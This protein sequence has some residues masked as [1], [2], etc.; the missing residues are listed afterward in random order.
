MILLVRHGRT[1]MNAA[2]RLQGRVDAP[3][4]EL[5]RAQARA[6]GAVLP[7]ADRIVCSPLAR[8]RQTAEIIAGGAGI[9]VDDRW[10]ELDYGDWDGQPLGEVPRDQWDRWR[11]DITFA[12]PG[13]ESLQSCAQRVR[14]ACQELADEATRSDVVVVSHVSPIKAAV[15]WALGVGDE[16][17]W[18]MFLAVAS[19]CRVAVSDRGPSLQSYN[20][21]HHLDSLSRPVSGVDSL[22]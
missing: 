15:A 5:G 20:E 18:R 9:D 1:E 22:R 19:I 3:L 14:A 17:S 6:L 8:A 7:E 2:G 11:Q 13:G 12:P 4:D 21:Q 16:A 10:I